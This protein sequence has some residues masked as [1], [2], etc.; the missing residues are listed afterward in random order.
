MTRA[1]V[2]DYSTDRTAG[3]DISRWIPPDALAG[4][5]T[6]GSQDFPDPMEFTHVVHS[7]SALSICDDAP[8]QEEAETFIRRAVDGGVRQMGICYG[9]QLLARAVSGRDA[10]RR[11]P[12]GG[13]TGWLEVLWSPFASALLGIPRS[14]RL[15]Q[16]HY[17]EVVRL[18]DGAAVLAWSPVSFIESFVSF[19]LGLFGV[20]FHPEFGREPGNAL[21]LRERAKIE[22]KGLDPELIVRGGP[23]PDTDGVFFRA[24]LGPVW[25]GR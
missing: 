15:F 17:D 22:S 7:G 25:N 14:T 9:H 10:V 23:E 8:F 12:S 3:A 18:P 4:V 11:N 13:E 20:Q 19:D 1:L 24:F 6:P 2:I 21:F 5:F 16:F